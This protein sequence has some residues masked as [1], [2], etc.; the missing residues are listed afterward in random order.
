MPT[1]Y[2]SILLTQPNDG[3]VV[4]VRRFVRDPPILA[5]WIAPLRLFM[6]AGQLDIQIE[7][8]TLNGQYAASWQA[9]LLG[10]GKPGW[11][12]TTG[13]NNLYFL[14]QPWG[15]ISFGAQDGSGNGFFAPAALYQGQIPACFAFTPNGT[16]PF[17]L[18]TEMAFT[19]H[20]LTQLLLPASLVSAWRPQ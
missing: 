20:T 19:P 14:P 10:S 9:N 8:T 1:L 2:R 7:G 11:L 17:G 12:A 13:G 6:Q 5:T 18:P 3:E 4:Y 16:N 15:L